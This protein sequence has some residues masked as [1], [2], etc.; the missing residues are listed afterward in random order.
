[1]MVSGRADGACG[2]GL[3]ISAGGH[4]GVEQSVGDQLGLSAGKDF[5]VGHCW[6]GEVADGAKGVAAA[7]SLPES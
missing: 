6:S 5:S 4:Q 1:M 3:A 7:S 2:A